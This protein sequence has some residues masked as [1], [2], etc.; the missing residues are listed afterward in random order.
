MNTMKTLLLLSFLAV[1]ANLG[2]AHLGVGDPAPKLDN[3]KWVQGE[4]VKTFAPDKAYIV[5]FWATWCGPCR[6]S[7][8]HLNQVYRK[9]KD[10][11]LVVIGQDV[12]ERDDGLV[13][14]FVEK[15]GNNMTYRVAL[16]NKTAN[17]KGAMA[18]N[19]MEAAGQEGIPTAFLIGKDGK[20]AWIGHP[21]QLEES[22]IEEV[23]E[24]K[25][26]PEQAKNLAKAMT[27]EREIDV[28]LEAK[29][30]DEA[31]AK[32]AE[33][34]RLAPDLKSALDS[35]RFQ[36]LV[37]KGN[38]DGAAELAEKIC[39]AGKAEAP[40]LNQYAWEL[41]TQ[42]GLKG[43]ALAAAYRIAA[44]ANESAH[45]TDPSILDT[46]ARAAFMKGEKDQAIQWQQKA[47]NL[48]DND[49]ARKQFKAA[50]D[51]YQSGKLPPAN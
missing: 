51:S 5:E 12:F 43:N 14:P 34:A 37:G 16:D 4:P 29:K 49:R 21:M 48:A 45:G 22:V 7:I 31:E 40:E 28:A 46:L 36:L 47:V 39:G 11:G 33:F 30:W 24:G 26:T 35:S 1:G 2:A 10:R 38:L 8:P 9:F 27:I 42:D 25:F 17:K 50:L 15:M 18:E 20:I 41:L 13:K 6:A 3:G 44:K 19:W 23:I 32:M